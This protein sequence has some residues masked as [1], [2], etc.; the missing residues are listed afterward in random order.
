VIGV[1]GVMSSTA[2]ATVVKVESLP[3]TAQDQVVKHLR[4]YLEDLQDELQWDSLLPD[5]PRCSGGGPR[6]EKRRQEVNC[7][8][9]HTSA[10]AWS[11]T[12]A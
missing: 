11:D 10:G 9:G 3:E 12:S 5:P 8:R 6:G 1:A 4:A 2:I 7:D